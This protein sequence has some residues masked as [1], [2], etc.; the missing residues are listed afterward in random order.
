VLAPTA[1]GA[2]P[3][4]HTQSGS[5]DTGDVIVSVDGQAVQGLSQ[6][7]LKRQHVLDLQPSVSMT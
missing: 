2:G 4:P 1:G 7:R 6:A 3:Q 5:I